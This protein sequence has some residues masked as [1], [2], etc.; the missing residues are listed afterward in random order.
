MSINNFNLRFR[1][2]QYFLP[3]LPYFLHEAYVKSEKFAER[4]HI[5]GVEFE[6]MPV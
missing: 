4:I 6:R 1:L 5:V 2:C 3:L